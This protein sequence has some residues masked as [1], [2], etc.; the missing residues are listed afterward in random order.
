MILD[1]NIKSFNHWNLLTDRTE[2]IG[3]EIQP[4]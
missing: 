3:I 4:F 2:V 1:K